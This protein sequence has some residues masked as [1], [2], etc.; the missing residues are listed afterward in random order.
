MTQRD[1]AAAR[2]TIRLGAIAANY[3]K[4][5]EICSPAA[6]AA[7]V[8]ADAYGLGLEPVA[9]VL[10]EAGCDSFFV[11]RMEEGIALRALQPRTRI[12]VLD[13]AQPETASA[14]IAHRLIPVLNSLSEIATWNEAAQRAGTRLDCAVHLDTGMNRLGLPDYER[15]VLSAEAAT[16]LRRLNVVLWISHLACGDNCASPMNAAQLARFRAALA[17][18]PAAPASLA[19][20]AG[21]LLGKDYHF[22]LIRPGIG[23]YGGNPCVS[24]PNP[25]AV[26]A[27]LTGR[28]LQ[29]RRVDTGE[30]VG[31]GASF[32]AARPSTLATIGL[33]YADGLM[34]AIG[35]RGVGA[36]GGVRVPVVGRVS[37]DLVTLD[38]SH[39]PPDALA[40][41][42]EAEFFGDTI[43]LDE[44]AV[45]AG[46]A[47]YEVLTSLGH[48]MPRLY[49]A[50]A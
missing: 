21:A 10:T 30:T 15:A 35:N 26:V 44:F 24:Q 16:R 46:T 34:R 9:Q 29:L 5:Q 25:F 36:I 6:V 48:R 43:S 37:M 41:G 39:V 17:N 7:A 20:S 19:A 12:F 2:L 27:V 42:A 47:N 32:R 13:G 8:K 40:V 45:Q 14:L 28:I 23:L 22:D 31:Y 18:L 11:A 1:F 38:V 4:F 33:G 3:R 50:A 49:E